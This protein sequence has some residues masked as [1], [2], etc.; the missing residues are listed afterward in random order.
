VTGNNLLWNLIK[1]S[2]L[3]SSIFDLN[4][5][6]FKLLPVGLSC[7]G[8]IRN[9]IRVGDKNPR[10]RTGETGRPNHELAVQKLVPN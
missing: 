4:S 6:I 2:S 7:S 1:S 8:S 3:Q 9:R 5:S 10:P